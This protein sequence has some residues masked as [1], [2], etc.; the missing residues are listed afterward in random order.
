MELSAIF[1]GWGVGF[2]QS[3]QKPAKVYTNYLVLCIFN[4][5][6]RLLVNWLLG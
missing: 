3:G 2:R 1:E 4:A 5:P 6:R